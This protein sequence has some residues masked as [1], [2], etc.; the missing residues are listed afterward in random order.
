[1]QEGRKCPVED[2]AIDRQLS[3]QVDTLRVVLGIHEATMDPSVLK[4]PLEEM[5]VYDDYLSY[6]EILS[7]WRTWIKTQK[8]TG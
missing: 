3:E 2:L 1:M 6:A 5:G 8:K 4:K 7:T